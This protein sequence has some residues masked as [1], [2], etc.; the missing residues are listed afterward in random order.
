MEKLKFYVRHCW[1]ELLAVIILS[2]LAIFVM[3]GIVCARGGGHGGHSGR[4]NIY[5]ADSSFKGYTQDQGNGRVNIYD[6][7]SNFRGYEQQNS[8]GSVSIYNEKSTRIET[9]VPTDIGGER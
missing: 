8:D 9:I 3:S 7:K 1:K 5:G 6:Q 4:S 2:I